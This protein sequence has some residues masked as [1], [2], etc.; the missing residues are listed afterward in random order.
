MWIL[1][2]PTFFLL[3]S[4]IW[5]RASEPKRSNEP[6]PYPMALAVN[7][8]SRFFIF[9]CAL[10]NLKKGIRYRGSGKKFSF[11]LFHRQKQN[12]TKQKTRKQKQCGEEA[13]KETKRLRPSPFYS[14]SVYWFSWFWVGRWGKKIETENKNKKKKNSEKRRPQTLASLPW[15]LRT[16]RNDHQID[17]NSIWRKLWW[18]IS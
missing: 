6:W 12:K 7:K 17:T 2:P 11:S 3:F 16:T 5:Q 15:S 1:C 8:S 9:I 18:S 13:K 4:T 10:E 14:L